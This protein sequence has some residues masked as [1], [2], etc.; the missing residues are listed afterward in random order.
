MENIS[1]FGLSLQLTASSTFPNGVT[2]SAFADD[3]DPLDSP[4]LEVA[5][6]SMGPNGDTVTWSRPELIEV[7]INVIPQ[8]Q[9]DINL[10]ALLDAN[11]VAKNK[12]SAADEIGIVATYPNGL[13]ATATEG[14]LT[15]G[16]AIQS[17]TSQ[18]RSK[19]KRFVFKFAQISRQQP[20]A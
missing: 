5:N 20:T 1:I 19:S 9:D 16:P 3:A 14:K 6:M 11:R 10:T 12:S 17:G 2:I 13:K 7:V 4:D 18:G 8:S 15:A